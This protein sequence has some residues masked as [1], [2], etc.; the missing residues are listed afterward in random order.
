[1]PE[2]FDKVKKEIQPVQ[3]LLFDPQTNYEQTESERRYAIR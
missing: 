3:Y 2:Y 1:M